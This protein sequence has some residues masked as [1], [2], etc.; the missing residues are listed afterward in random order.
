MFPSKITSGI[1]IGKVL[2]GISKTLNII[3]QMLPIYNQAKPMINNSKKI[4]KALKEFTIN[5]KE[6]SK[7]E[8]K[9]L[10]NKKTEK[11]NNLPVFFS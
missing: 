11:L 5:D 2:G 3:N 1:T 6:T 8:I 10:P 4:Y 9:E 7:S